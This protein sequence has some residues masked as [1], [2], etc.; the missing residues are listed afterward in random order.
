MSKTPSKD[1]PKRSISQQE[2]APWCQSIFDGYLLHLKNKKVKESTVCWYKGIANRCLQ[3]F[4][5]K[6]ASQVNGISYILMRECVFLIE[7]SN[8][9]GLQ[10]FARFIGEIT[11][12]PYFYLIARFNQAVRFLNEIDIQKFR[13]LSKGGISVDHFSKLAHELANY[14][15]LNGYSPRHY[16]IPLVIEKDFCLFLSAYQLSFTLEL[17]ELWTQLMT[18][19]AQLSDVQNYYLTFRLIDAMSKG[20]DPAEDRLCLKNPPAK[21]HIPKW[22]QGLV[23]KYIEDR[24]QDRLSHNAIRMCF[25]SVARFLCYADLH[26]IASFQNISPDLI[27]NF[28]KDDCN[29]KTAASKN[30]YNVRIRHFLNWL[31][32]GEIINRDLSNA[33]PKNSA[34]SVRPVTILTNEQQDRLE[35]YC[36]QKTEQSSMYYRDVA[37]LKLMR[38]LGL[39]VVDVSELKFSSI[40]LVKQ[41]LNITQRKT[42]KVLKLP[43]PTHVLNSL[44]TYIEKERPRPLVKT[45][46]VF[47]SARGPHR[48]MAPVSIRR[49]LKHSLGISQAHILRRTFASELM[50]GQTD[51]SLVAQSLGHSDNSTVHKYLN[52]DQQRMHSCSLP[53]THMQYRGS[54]I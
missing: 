6:G 27:K 32:E 33:L 41:E 3:Y 17:G 53:L 40:N 26:G 38:Y 13:T 24:K 52:T 46:Y 45:D 25:A 15:K 12:R 5:A 20:H 21:T 31:Y 1:F 43:I 49:C 8:H 22:A 4:S 30:A 48:K 44:I 39:R 9:P 34:P 19:Q 10:D 47:L 54:L 35:Q 7:G 16:G 50:N 51:L 42:G 37:M 14:R 29:H 23:S 18:Q 11:D 28:N 2:L 36:L